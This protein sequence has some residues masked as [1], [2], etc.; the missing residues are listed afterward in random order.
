MRL[1][2]S[3]DLSMMKDKLIALKKS[4]IL[5]LPYL[6][7]LL[8]TQE[9]SHHI[10]VSKYVTQQLGDSSVLRD[11]CM[12]C[13]PTTLPSIQ[14]RQF[15]QQISGGKKTAVVQEYYVAASG[16]LCVSKFQGVKSRAS[17]TSGMHSTTQPYPQLLEGI[18][19]KDHIS[20]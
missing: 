18:L 8:L 3:I 11:P 15:N 2:N 16:H 19:V 7:H 1:L 10:S 17:C 13:E 20:P 5:F 12:L 9:C 14:Y 4:F 6:T